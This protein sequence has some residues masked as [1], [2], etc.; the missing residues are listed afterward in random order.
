MPVSSSMTATLE[1][2]REYPCGPERGMAGEGHLV[3]GIED[4]HAHRAARFRREDERRLG[5]ADLLRK[6][7]HQL[8]SISRASVN[9]ASWFP[10]SAVSV[11]T[12]TTT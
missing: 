10:V 2:S 1:W 3:R 12:S 11:K 8:S 5:E 9:T 7:L 4:A 6:C